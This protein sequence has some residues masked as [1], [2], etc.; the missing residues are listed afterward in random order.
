MPTKKFNG[1]SHTIPNSESLDGM[2]PT[3]GD[4]WRNPFQNVCGGYSVCHQ[5]QMPE[6]PDPES[7][8]QDTWKKFAK[9][10]FCLI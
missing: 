1:N 7:L 2:G 6:V 3:N 9:G 5:A 4:F 8:P 10:F